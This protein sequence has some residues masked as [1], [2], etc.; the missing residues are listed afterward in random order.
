MIKCK[1]WRKR[2]EEIPIELSHRERQHIADEIHGMFA[3]GG[4]SF[5]A[6]DFEIEEGGAR[7]C[8]SAWLARHEL[9]NPFTRR[10]PA[11]RRGRK[12]IR[13]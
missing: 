7:S 6:T 5:Q 9:T 4:S 13:N 1:V 12:P 11:A 3:I 10:P 8:L 2:A